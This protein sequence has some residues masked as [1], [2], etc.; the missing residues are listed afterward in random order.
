MK[1]PL[2]AYGS[3]RIVDAAGV[4]VAVVRTDTPGKHA[5]AGLDR[6]RDDIVRA[7]NAH[8]ALVTYLRAAVERVQL[9]VDDGDC[10]MLAAWLPEAKAA[11]A[12]AKGDKP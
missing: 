10:P 5:Q 4:V 3:D 6:N 1:P 7:V 12:L 9:A 2:K 8:D 11:L